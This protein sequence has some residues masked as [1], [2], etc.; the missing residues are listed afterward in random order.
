MLISIQGE[1]VEWIGGRFCN[2]KLQILPGADL[3]HPE[4]C[5]RRHMGLSRPSRRQANSF[6]GSPSRT[7]VTSFDVGF[8]VG[9][10]A[11]ATCRS[12]RLSVVT[13]SLWEFLGDK[14]AKT[15]H[16]R[17]CNRGISQHGK[18]THLLLRPPGCVF[19]SALN[20]WKALAMFENKCFQL[21]I[22]GDIGIQ[23][24]ADI[25]WS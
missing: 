24:Y 9:T 1:G 11:V 3:K 4:H 17:L 25:M 10:F 12:G 8:D 2:K 15:T 13:S 22:R 14:G 19:L 20:L 23:W 18:P 6:C 16:R 21:Y 5:F 7:F